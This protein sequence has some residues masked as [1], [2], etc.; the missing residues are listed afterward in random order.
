VRQMSPAYRRVSSRCLPPPRS[1]EIK[2]K[3]WL[4]S[5]WTRHQPKEKVRVQQL[6]CARSSVS[7]FSFLLFIITFSCTAV[8]FIIMIKWKQSWVQGGT[9]LNCVSENYFLK[10][11]KW[12]Q[13]LF[14]KICMRRTKKLFFHTFKLYLHWEILRTHKWVSF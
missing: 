13:K 12:I 1:D 6:V 8:L 10:I 5:F 7:I 14:S 9:W 4:I 11:R 3:A 2:T